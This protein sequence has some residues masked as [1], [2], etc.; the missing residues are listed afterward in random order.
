MVFLISAIPVIIENANLSPFVV[1]L[2]NHELTPTIL[3]QAQDERILFSET[4][5]PLI[6]GIYR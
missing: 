1:S 6:M 3:R 5:T 2:S 4:A